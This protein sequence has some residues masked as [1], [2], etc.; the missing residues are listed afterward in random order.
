MEIED[1]TPELKEKLKACKTPEEL[2][3]LVEA[4]GIELTEEQ[5]EDVA[6]GAYAFLTSIFGGDCG[7]LGEHFASPIPK[8]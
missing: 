4:E 6:G 3:G 8:F 7:D 2:M 5:L 1:L